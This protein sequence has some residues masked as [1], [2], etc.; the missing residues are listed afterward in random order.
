MNTRATWLKA[1]DAQIEQYLLIRSGGYSAY[2]EKD[3]LDRKQSRHELEV[4]ETKLL[5]ADPV[6]VTAEMCELVEV[7]QRTFTPEP[8]REH[9][10]MTKAGFLLFERPVEVTHGALGDQIDLPYAGFSW[11]S[12]KETEE[13]PN[14]YAAHF[15][16][17]VDWD[18]LDGETREQLKPLAGTTSGL[19][20]AES[21]NLWFGEDPKPSE[22]DRRRLVQTTFRLM[23]EFKP[24]SRYST[25]ERPDRAT[26]KRAKRAGLPEPEI[27]VVRL[28]RE[29]SLAERI[30]GSA[31]YAYRFMVSGHWR[32]QWFP[33]QHEHRQV[34]ISPYVKGPGD[35]PF[36]PPQGRV[37]NLFR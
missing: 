12:V 1:L 9:E 25:K 10:L 17:Y 31:N 24:A 5:L 16:F 19:L 21:I 36:K 15:A 34:W 6:F 11:A 3:Y 8:L 18:N 28:R 13:S 37:F 4:E 2:Q 7:A 23:R 14:P 26:R 29:R 35:K 33:T 30:G 22:R 27:L 20:L 32:N